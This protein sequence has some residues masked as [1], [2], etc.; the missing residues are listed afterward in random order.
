MT[1][2]RPVI[3]APGLL[4]WSLLL[5]LG[6]LL[7][8]HNPPWAAFHTDAWIALFAAV[9]SI[10]VILRSRGPVACHGVAALALLLAAL[11]W[12]QYFFGIIPMAG[13]A[14]MAS[15]YPLG[16]L[17]A[18]LTAAMCALGAVFSIRRVTRIDPTSVFVDTTAR[19]GQAATWLSAGSSRSKASAK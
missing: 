13:S 14:W 1:P 17:L 11:P 10:I 3:P 7:P 2:I 5:S 18:L 4:L 12:L 15:L 9:I 6:W 8:V 19:V 16:L